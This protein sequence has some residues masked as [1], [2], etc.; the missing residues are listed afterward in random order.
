[1]ALNLR[2][3][4][5][6]RLRLSSLLDGISYLVLLGI[7]MP[8]KYMADMPMAVRIVG[9][10]HGLFFLA[11]CLFLLIALLRKQLTFGWCAFVFLCALVPFAPFWL[12]HRLKE[13]KA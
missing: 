8:L 12:D 13:K 7:A 10:L 5:I 9:S 2:S 3:S 6:D 1:M 4:N 11:L